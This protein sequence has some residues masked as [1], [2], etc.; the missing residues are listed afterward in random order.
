MSLLIQRQ[1]ALCFFIWQNAAR[2]YHLQFHFILPAARPVPRQRQD[3]P[4]VH[5]RW[6]PRAEFLRIARLVLP[7]YPNCK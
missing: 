5:E 3:D 2:N 6:R 4:A 1:S 7:P